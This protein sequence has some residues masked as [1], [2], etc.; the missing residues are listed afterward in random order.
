MVGKLHR[1]PWQQPTASKKGLPTTID[2]FDKSSDVERTADPVLEIQP[3][4]YRY[5][6]WTFKGY[7]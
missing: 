3:T 4:S 5:V 6:A 1:A 7:N 2:N